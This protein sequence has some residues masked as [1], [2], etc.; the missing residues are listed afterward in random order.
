[1]SKTS[2]SEPDL[3]K[4]I[5]TNGSLGKI[6]YSNVKAYSELIGEEKAPMLKEEI[7]RMK[8]NM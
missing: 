6:L 4:I 7:E 8:L 1:L 2:L 5:K 3:A